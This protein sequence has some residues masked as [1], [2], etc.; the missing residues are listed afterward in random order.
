MKRRRC[1]GRWAF[2]TD[3]RSGGIIFA[4]NLGGRQQLKSVRHSLMSKEEG[5]ENWSDKKAREQ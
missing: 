5:K 1:K 4:V 2:R 3:M